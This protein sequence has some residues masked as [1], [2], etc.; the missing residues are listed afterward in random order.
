[1]RYLPRNCLYKKD[2]LWNNT[3]MNVQ[4][5]CIFTANETDFS[6]C[7][8]IHQSGVSFFFCII[9]SSSVTVGIYPFYLIT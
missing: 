4:K 6:D 7:P 8:M 1:M 5:H 3:C 9:H 2:C